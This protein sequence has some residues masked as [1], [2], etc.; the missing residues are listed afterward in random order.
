MTEQRPH[1]PPS[2]ALRAQAS[3]WFSQREAMAHNPLLRQRFEQWHAADPQHAA[4]YAELQ[5]LWNASA[6]EQA[7]QHLALDLELP[8]ARP[9]VRHHRRWLASA[10]ALVLML[11]AGW[12]ADVP[13]RLQADHLTAV[14]QVQR[15]EL[16]DGSHVVLGGD[17]AISS[18]INDRQRHIRLL[19]GELYVEAF[20]DTTRPLTIEA[21]E[22][23]VTVVGTQFSVSRREQ[24]V[25]VAVREG[26]V[27][28][29]NHGGQQ[30]L[31]QAG[32]WQ[33]LRDGQLQALNLEGGERQMAWVN[34]RL[35]FQ[36]RPLAEV[37]G[38][39]RHYYP[40]PIL[41]LDDRVAQS[42]VSGNYQLDDPLAVAQA[43]S[44]VASA[45]LTR[46][47]GGILVIR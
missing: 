30:A 38:E 13:L 12:M 14:A 27:R 39:L 35:S 20:H 21:G 8:P 28:F 41:V 33:Q 24:G 16:A 29:A 34:G 45:Q 6:F 44:K 43:L 5:A 3:H 11:G 9:R 7:L 19:R 23:T 40:A 31:L 1:A 15:L 18:E 10:A 2:A 37:L 47:P 22:S 36:D 46:L 32:N 42:R 17:S 4:A 25:T 26:R